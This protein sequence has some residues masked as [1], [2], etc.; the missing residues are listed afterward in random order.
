MTYES[1]LDDVRQTIATGTSTG[2]VVFWPKV[3][4]T[5][6]VAISGSAT[7]SLFKPGDAADAVPFATGTA[8]ATTVGAVTKLTITVNA[9]STTSL[10][11]DEYYRAT[12]AWTYSSTPYVSNVFFDICRDPFSPHVSLNDVVEEVSDMEVRCSAQAVRMESGRTADQHAS[13]LGVKAWNDVQTWIRQQAE[14]KGYILPYAIVDHE[15]IRRVTVAKTVARIYRAEGG[16]P[17]S[18][19]WQLADWWD[20]EA[21]ARFEGLPPIR[22]DANQDSAMDSELGGF[23]VIKMSRRW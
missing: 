2:S 16:G 7:Y 19:S 15:A 11:I 14:S 9:T 3:A 21:K 18:E 17:D 5:G 23:G 6:N 8:T 1:E 20:K 13:V 22:Y 10:P 12:I 4:G